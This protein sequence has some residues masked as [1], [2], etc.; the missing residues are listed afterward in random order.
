MQSSWSQTTKER[1]NC[2]KEREKIRGESGQA[3]AAE[4]RQL[5]V[6][7]LNAKEVDS[8]LKNELLRDDRE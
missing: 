1:F 3:T 5:D 2:S 4:E 6:I 7:L 8:E